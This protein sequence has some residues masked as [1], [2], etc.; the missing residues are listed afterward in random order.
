MNI[1]QVLH[2]LVSAVGGKSAD[3]LAEA[4]DAIDEFESFLKELDPARFTPPA[5]VDPRV[6]QLADLKAQQ[7]KLEAELSAA[8][9]SPSS[10][11]PAPPV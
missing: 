6:Q 7:A 2:E 10:E 8:P 1:A 5:P 4:H 9:S 3:N 11:I